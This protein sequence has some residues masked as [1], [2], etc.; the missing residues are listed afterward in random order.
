[1]TIKKF[2]DDTVRA[3]QAGMNRAPHLYFAPLIG[4]WNGAIRENRKAWDAL[5]ADLA[6]GGKPFRTIMRNSFSTYFAPLVGA[7]KGMSG[8]R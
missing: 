2:M 6:A 5:N 4:A 7:I 3:F 1:M 8:C